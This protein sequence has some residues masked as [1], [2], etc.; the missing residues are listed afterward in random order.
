MPRVLRILNRLI[1]GGPSKNAVYL[2]RYMQ[3]DFD[4]LLVI[5]GKEDHEQ[6]ADFLAAA[7]NIEPR[8]I[9]EMKRPISPRNDWAA[10]NKL[11]KLIKEFKP[12]IVHTHAAK[13]GA[14][15]RLAAKHAGVPVIVHTFH[16]HV[17]H[18]Y[19]NSLKTNFF[20]RS[21][22]YLA[23]LS[24]A[25]VAISDVQKKELAGEFKIAKEDKFRVIPLGLDLDNFTIDQA[26]KRNK[27]RSEFSLDYDTVAI[28]I[29][30]RLVPVKNH[31]LF[32]KALKYVL[33]NTSAKVKAFI[34]GDGESRG[35][36]EQLANSLGIKFS[37]HTDKDHPHPLVFTS[38]RTD[39]DII[40]SGLDIIALTSLN[41]GT[42]VSLIEAQAAGKPIV[43]TRVGGI[44]DVVLEDQTA[45]LSD[46]NDEKH[47]SENLLRLVNDVSL[48]NK[49]SNSGKDF[50]ISKFSYH[51]LVKDMRSLYYDLLEKKNHNGKK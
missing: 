20:I 48:R 15:G 10:Y 23:G 30:G 4:T 21:E 40:C 46:I 29:I 50:V 11:K 9:S 42:P 6:D 17:F 44:A 16:G 47:F 8:V 51:R 22:R 13:S 18:S 36:I 25:I 45:L 28:G 24:D 2:S 31:S 39:V 12:D 41:E 37:L 3:P 49:F 7:N 38:W 34:I 26:V 14:L 1:I 27:F 43:S 19:F 33:K 5:G 32:L 35:S